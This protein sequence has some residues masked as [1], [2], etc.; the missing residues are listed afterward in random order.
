MPNS[1]TV[2]G[3]RQLRVA[4]LQTDLRS[5][6]VGALD[7]QI[8]I[9]AA[10]IVTVSVAILGRPCGLLERRADPWRRLMPFD[11]RGGFGRLQDD[12]DLLGRTG[13]AT[14]VIGATTGLGRTA[15]SSLVTVVVGVRGTG[16]A[17]LPRGVR[18]GWKTRIP[19]ATPT[20]RAA[21]RTTSAPTWA[22]TRGRLTVRCR[23]VGGGTGGVVSSAFSKGGGVDGKELNS[24]QAMPVRLGLPAEGGSGLL[25]V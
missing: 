7:L 11:D 3:G 20:A 10:V 15:S 4:R 12:L 1:S 23:P 19:A 16:E 2:G 5:G 24:R 18:A 8:A 25:M 17:V 22:M 14:G 13:G 21:A 6:H 9:T